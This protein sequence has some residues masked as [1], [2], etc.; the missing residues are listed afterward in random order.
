VKEEN[1]KILKELVNNPEADNTQ[2]LFAQIALV[3]ESLDWDIARIKA[4]INDL[5]ARLLQNPPAV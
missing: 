2:Q 5:K 1:R 3:L 4:D